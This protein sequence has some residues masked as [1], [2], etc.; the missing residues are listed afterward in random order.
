MRSTFHRG[1]LQ[2]KVSKTLSCHLTDP[3]HT[4]RGFPASLCIGLAPASGALGPELRRQEAKSAGLLYGNE[5]PAPLQ[6]QVSA[7]KYTVRCKQDTSNGLQ[8]V[9]PAVAQ[10]KKIKNELGE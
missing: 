10:K 2:K 9:T 5:T 7:V 6:L 4:A 8:Q 3:S 1:I